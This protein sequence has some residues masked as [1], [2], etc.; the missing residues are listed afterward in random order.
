VSGNLTDRATVTGSRGR[1]IGDFRI[2]LTVAI[3]RELGGYGAVL[4]A[5]GRWWKN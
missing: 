1:L 2:T 4:D 3:G 5:L